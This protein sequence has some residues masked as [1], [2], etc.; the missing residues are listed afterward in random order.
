[1]SIVD[2]YASA[3]CAGNLASA[4]DTTFSN[5]DVLGAVGLAGKRT[6]GSETPDPRQGHPLATA[7]LRLFTGGDNNGKAVAEILARMLIGKAFRM[8]ADAP[9]CEV[10]A[11]AVARLVLEWHRD[12]VC[13]CCGGHGFMVAAG[14]LGHSRAVIG[15]VACDQCRGTGRRQFDALFPVLRLELAMWLRA[16][17]E[18][19][20][21]KAG[22]VAMRMLA[23]QA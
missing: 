4:P 19:E 2:R 17:V 8:D 18:R 15:D 22:S 12:S 5:S 6:L 9:I 1:M 11:M 23:P 7:L 13:K 16:E 20:T 10:E 3:V 21:S 14:E